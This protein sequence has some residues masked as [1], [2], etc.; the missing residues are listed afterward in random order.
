M[1]NKE[2]SNLSKN[3][4]NVPRLEITDL[5]YFCAFQTT[6]TFWVYFF[7]YMIDVQP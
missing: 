3:P 1:F 5:G 7:I 4:C 2:K 6:K